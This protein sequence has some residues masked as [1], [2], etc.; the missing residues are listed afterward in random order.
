MNR[1]LTPFWTRLIVRF[2]LKDKYRGKPEQKTYSAYDIA[3]GSYEFKLI[4]KDFFRDIFFI[5][6]G[7]L[8]A[9]FGLRGFLLTNDFI[10]GGATGISLLIQPLQVFHC[11]LYLSWSTFHL[12]CLDS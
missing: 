2:V 1:K 3:K 11:L 6:L 7:I 8:S 5:L 10:D 4:I 9:G 12:S